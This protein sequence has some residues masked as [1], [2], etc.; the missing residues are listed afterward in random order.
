MCETCARW[1]L[2]D[3]SEP[4]EHSSKTADYNRRLRQRLASKNVTPNLIRVT[5]IGALNILIAPK[6]TNGIIPSAARDLGRTLTNR[7]RVR[8]AHNLKVANSKPEGLQR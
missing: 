5:Q 7:A 8:G 2:H 6:R 3:Y 1:T 4:Q